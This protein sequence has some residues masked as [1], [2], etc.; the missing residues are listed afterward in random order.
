MVVSEVLAQV[1]LVVRRSLEPVT[2]AHPLTL[3][4]AQVASS[5]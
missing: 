3:L 4:V 2:V 1:A 5:N